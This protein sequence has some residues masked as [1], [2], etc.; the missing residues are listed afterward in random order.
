MRQ[1]RQRHAIACSHCRA[2][3]TLCDVETLQPCSWCDKNS[4][5]CKIPGNRFNANTRDTK[6]LQSIHN[7]PDGQLA[8]NPI[9]SITSFRYQQC[10]STTSYAALEQPY[11]L[12]SNI[13]GHINTTLPPGSSL[14]VFGASVNDLPDFIIPL[15]ERLEPDEIRYL[16]L[17]GALGLPDPELRNELLICYINY[18]HPFLPVLD[19][20]ATLGPISG[21]TSKEKVSLLLVQAIMYASIGFVSPGHLKRS[22][23][24]SKRS[25]RQAYYRKVKVL[26]EFDVE[27]DRTTLVQTLLLMTTWY[28]KPDEIKDAW[29]WLSLAITHAK[30]VGMDRLA[31]YNSASDVKLQLWKR[32]WWSCYIRDRLIA[33]GLRRPLQ[34]QEHEFSTPLLKLP[35]FNNLPLSTILGQHVG[36][37]TRVPSADTM[38]KLAR[39]VIELVKLCRHLGNVLCHRFCASDGQGGGISLKAHP[40]ASALQ[41]ERDMMYSSDLEAWYQELSDDL[42]CI[43]SPSG[44]ISFAKDE[45]KAVIVHIA[46]LT[47]IYNMTQITLHRASFMASQNGPGRPSSAVDMSA[48]QVRHSANTIMQVYKYLTNRDLIRY[49][50]HV[51]VT[52]LVPATLIFIVDGTSA[53]ASTRSEC[54]S[55]TQFCLKILRQLGET[56]ASADSAHSYILVARS[57]IGGS[58][59][60]GNRRDVGQDTRHVSSQRLVP[61]DEFLSS[62]TMPS[63]EKMAIYDWIQ[64]FQ[65]GEVPPLVIEEQVPDLQRL[66]IPFNIGPEPDEVKVDHGEAGLVTESHHDAPGKESTESVT[67]TLQQGGLQGLEAGSHSMWM[68]P[69]GPEGTNNPVGDHQNLNVER[70]HSSQQYSPQGYQMFCSLTDLDA[71]NSL[72]IAS[73]AT[74]HDHTP[75]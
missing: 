54:N 32:I 69:W 63:E 41:H 49:L 52:S 3:K 16:S 38:T 47:A 57:G 53:E 30:V 20:E 43:N 72:D 70:Q 5:V 26:Y 31:S 67:K 75:E 48:F 7:G 64:D 71:M 58:C 23:H 37:S 9:S 33:V 35:D 19:L 34:I 73:W 4:R 10:P 17:S 68:D 60:A 14:C 55:N 22:G 29:Y 51:A 6:L 50:P 56:Y 1:K 44:E 28:E 8:L 15:S 36:R 61:V 59:L 45:S 2:R 13:T 42:R 66:C 39:M 21:S 24:V 11:P 65:N 40:P 74:M 27:T 62:M 25:A 12:Q 18:V 46:V